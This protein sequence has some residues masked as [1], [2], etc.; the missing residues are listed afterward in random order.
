M[1]KQTYSSNEVSKQFLYYKQL[2]ALSQIK[3]I[4][5]NNNIK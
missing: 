1:K 2:E 3:Q 4:L 5:F